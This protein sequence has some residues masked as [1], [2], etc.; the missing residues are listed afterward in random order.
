MDW[1][2]KGWHF[3]KKILGVCNTYYQLITMIQLKC[4]LFRNDYVAVLVSDH[5]KNTRQ[6]VQNLKASNCFEAVEFIETKSLDYGGHGMIKKIVGIFSALKGKPGCNI[7]LLDKIVFDEF[8]YFNNG[9][10]TSAIGERLCRI[11]NRLVCSQYEESI[12]SYDIAAKHG[13]FR[14]LS[15]RMK[16]VYILQTITGKR[17]VSDLCQKFCCYYPEYYHGKCSTVKIPLLNENEEF[18]KI[19][20]KV[21][22]LDKSSFE[23]KQKYIFFSSV[24]DFEGGH[25]IGEVNLAKRIAGL[26]GKENLLL[27]LHPRDNTGTFEKAGFNIDKNSD[28]PW[29]AIQLNYDF[30]NHVFL[31]ATSTSVLTINLLLEKHPKVYFLY[32]LCDIAG[33]NAVKPS[34]EA[35]EKIFHE[36]NGFPF[37]G[38]YLSERLSD[39]L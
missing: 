21:F 24:G 9:L 19:I 23:Y 31:T 8:M 25:P 6:I 30:G 15:K 7:R 2:I 13:N 1:Y 26:V 17:R 16:V 11:N 4:T 39:I 12:L 14:E 20:S 37:S 29:E 34:V 5:S 3:M 36:D 33:N 35:L 28:I 38:I 27:K 32:P 22:Q 10:S 18:K